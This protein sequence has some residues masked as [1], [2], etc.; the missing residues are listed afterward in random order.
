MY[1]VHRGGIKKKTLPMCKST[2]HVMFKKFEGNFVHMYFQVKIRKFTEELMTVTDGCNK[3]NKIS[4]LL[5]NNIHMWHK[6][7]V[8]KL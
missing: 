5:S 2:A 8:E 1:Y 7:S 3:S 6:L 4:K